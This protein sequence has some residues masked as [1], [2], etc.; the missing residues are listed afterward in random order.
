MAMDIHVYDTYIKARDQHIMHFDVFMAQKDD[1]LA[2]QYAKQWL[3]SIGEAGAL[4]SSDE[5][6]FCHTQQAPAAVIDTINQQ[7]YYIYQMEGCPN[8]SV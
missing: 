6:R 8:P 7:G 2:I 5:C 4:V 1:D 3:A